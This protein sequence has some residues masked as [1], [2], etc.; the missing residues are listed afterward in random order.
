MRIYLSV[1]VVLFVFSTSNAF[2]KKTLVYCSEGSPSS[3]N[4]QVATDGS[5][6]NVTRGIYNQ[7]VEFKYGETTIEPALAQSW[8]VS[9]DNLTYTF[10]LRKKVYFHSTPYFKPTRDFNADDVIFSF[11]RQ[12]DSSNAYHK[13]GGASYEYFV[14]MDMGKIIKEI[15]KIDNYTVQFVLNKPEAPFLANL[16]MDFASILSKE[17]ADQ[18]LAK[19]SPEKIDFEPVGTGPFVFKRYVKDQTVRLSA[20]DGYWKR[21]AKIDDLVFTI[22]TEPS[23][24]FQKLRTGECHFVTEPAP[25]DLAAMKKDKNIKVMEKAGLNIG[26][27]A[28]NVQ[29]KPF[30]NVLVRQ[31]VNMALNR[32]A[33]IQAIYLGNAMVAKNPIPPT[34]WGYAKNTK[35]YS[36]NTAK[37]KALLAKAGYPN[38]FETEL[39]TLPVSRPYNPNGKK[40]GEMM[41]ADLAK[42]GVKAKLVTYDWPTYLEKSKNGLHQLLQLGWT[43][44][45]GDPD[46]FLYVLLSC[47]AVEGGANRSRWCDKNFDSLVTQAK[48]TSNNNKRTRLYQQAQA[49]FKKEAPWVTIAHAKVFRAM[50]NK[51]VGYKIDPFGGDYFYEVD[52][53]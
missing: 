36:F 52:L 3:F 27:L 15:K 43:G 37:A 14:S 2:A 17:Y 23:V 33:Y 32:D 25:A 22:T 9:K 34:M 28:M 12:M 41:Q 49:R 1:L 53:R 10:N 4:P 30:D 48:Q 19:K 31:A 35:D 40:M 20:N 42:I 29:K 5:T 21:R 26:Y 24:R 46:N 7:L 38:G 45:N 18:L 47:S 39:W 44:D 16:A 11:Q 8:K 6:F 13:V 50:S 51:V